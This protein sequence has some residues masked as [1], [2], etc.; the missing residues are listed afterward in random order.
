[1]ADDRRTSR[2]LTT[3]S[4]GTLRTSSRVRTGTPSFCT[5]LGWTT[6]VTRVGRRGRMQAV[7]CWVE[8]NCPCAQ[9]PY[10]HQTARDGWHRPP[11]LHIHRVGR[12][13]PVDLVC[14]LRRPRH[15]RCRQ[16]RCFV[17]W[18]DIPGAGLHVTK[19]EGLENQAGVALARNRELPI[20][21]HCRAV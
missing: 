17:P 11:D 20:L 4:R 12:P 9:P 10:G 8:A 7:E 19:A 1:M 15:E 16:P 6:L 2:R 21:Q 5:I 14:R 18:G 13:P 3:M